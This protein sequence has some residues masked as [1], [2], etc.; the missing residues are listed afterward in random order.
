MWIIQWLVTGW[1]TD[2]LWLISQQR[3]DIL[4]CGHMETH[5]TRQKMQSLSVR[6]QIH[7]VV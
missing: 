6:T 3:Y 5:Q 4:V 7:A 2:E 1:G